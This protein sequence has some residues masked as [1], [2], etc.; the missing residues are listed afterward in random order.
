MTEKLSS[1]EIHKRAGVEFLRTGYMDEI[2]RVA[3][4]T[5]IQELEEEIVQ[6][7]IRLGETPVEYDDKTARRMEIDR[8]EQAIAKARG[9]GD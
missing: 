5:R 8:R 9:Q 6:L 1:G 2:E 7:R 3:F 4:I